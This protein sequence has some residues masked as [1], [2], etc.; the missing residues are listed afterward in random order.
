MR[1]SYENTCKD[2]FTNSILQS[3]Y[4]SISKV[5]LTRLVVFKFENYLC[6]QY[7]RFLVFIRKICCVKYSSRGIELCIYDILGTTDI[8]R[9]YQLASTTWRSTVRN[10]KLIQICLR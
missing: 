8:L 4:Y 3:W 10:T 7:A 6:Q 9:Y 2:K 1:F 5:I